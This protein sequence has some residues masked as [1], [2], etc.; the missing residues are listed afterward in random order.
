MD[1]CHPRGDKLKM[2]S[3]YIHDPLTGDP[4]P[5]LGD[6]LFEAIALEQAKGFIPGGLEILSTQ[7]ILALGRGSLE[8]YS[9]VCRRLRKI[10]KWN[11]PS[12]RSPNRLISGSRAPSHLP[13]LSREEADRFWSR[14]DIKDEASDECWLWMGASDQKT[15]YG[16]FK[17]GG[18]NLAP[19]R[20]AFLLHWGGDPFPLLICHRCDV[21][22]CVSPH[23]LFLG[24]NVENNADRT[25]KGR[26]A[27][28]RRNGKYTK[29][30]RTPRGSA[31][32]IAKLTEADIIYIRAVFDPFSENF[33][34]A[35]LAIKFGVCIATIRHILQRRTWRHVQIEGAEAPLLLI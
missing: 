11:D 4:D 21:K 12:R 16:R 1:R 25:K 35:D 8:H 13:K 32:G 19:H 18:R 22:K 14:V 33:R 23:H 7:E 6:K 17:A 34:A 10:L 24:T 3:P 15:G 2:N 31:H 5:A 30:E 26:S 29:P 27:N 28:G 20:V 9:T